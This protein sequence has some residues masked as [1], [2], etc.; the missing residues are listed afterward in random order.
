MILLL[1]QQKKFNKLCNT[2][3]KT[4]VTQTLNFKDLRFE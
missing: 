3:E 4:K 1:K 2:S